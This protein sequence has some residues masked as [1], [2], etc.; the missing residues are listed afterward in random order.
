MKKNYFTL[1]YVYLYSLLLA[2]LD[3]VVGLRSDPNPLRFETF[4]MRALVIFTYL[5]VIRLVA[6]KAEKNG[7]SY[8]KFAL[9]TAVIIFFAALGI[10]FLVASL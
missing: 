8:R 1:P 5:L 10:S 7:Y 2:A 4:S 6:E 3:S 9:L